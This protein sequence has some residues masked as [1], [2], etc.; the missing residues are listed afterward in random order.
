M[1]VCIWEAEMGIVF[2]AD[3]GIRNAECGIEF[4]EL[5]GVAEAN[6]QCAMCNVQLNLQ[7]RPEGAP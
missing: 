1:I 6:E 2:N 7:K 5:K 4:A 3:F